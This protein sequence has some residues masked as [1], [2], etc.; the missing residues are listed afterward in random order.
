MQH[1]ASNS[2]QFI[3][4]N[5]F[6]YSSHVICTMKHPV[7]LHWLLV[8]VSDFIECFV[9]KIALQ[10]A[11]STDFNFSFFIEIYLIRK[12]IYLIWSNRIYCERHTIND[13]TENMTELF[14]FLMLFLC[15]FHYIHLY[16]SHSVHI[17]TE[18]FYFQRRTT[19]FRNSMWDRKLFGTFYFDSW[20][21]GLSLYVIV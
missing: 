16:H 15:W 17:T 8:I 1:L 4:E 18:C 9:H 20:A 10:Y 11:T 12:L 6:L 3:L 21:V 2:V 14:W 7:S 13:I 5:L 19:T